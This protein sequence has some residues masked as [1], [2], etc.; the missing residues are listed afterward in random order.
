MP[1]ALARSVN[2][3]GVDV[4]K[5]VGPVYGEQGDYR[6]LRISPTTTPKI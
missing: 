3:V 6:Y 4:G 1:R 5:R 2:T